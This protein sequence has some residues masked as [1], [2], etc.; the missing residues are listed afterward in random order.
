MYI[1]LTCYSFVGGLKEHFNV[2]VNLF[3][4]NDLRVIFLFKFIFTAKEVEDNAAAKPGEQISQRH[5]IVP[6]A[7]RWE[8]IMCMRFSECVGAT[9]AG[10]MKT[11]T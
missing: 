7:V 2:T 4:L 9:D 11:R 5:F 10:T 1:Y 8:T 6:E 3:T